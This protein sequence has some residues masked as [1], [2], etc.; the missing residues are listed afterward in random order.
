[1]RSERALLFGGQGAYA[2]GALMKLEGAAAGEVR[3]VLR[4]V[5][6]VAGE[7][8]RAGVS[9]LLRSAGGPGAAELAERDPFAL[10]LAIF[11]IGVAGQR[12]ASSSGDA[13]FVGHSMG[14]IAALTAAGAFELADGARLV[15]HRAEALAAACRRRGGMLSVQLS[16]ARAA[17][18][19]ELVDDPEAAVAVRNAPGLT[20]LA[21]PE[22]ALA[23]FVRIADAMHVRSSRLPAPYAF[24]SPMMALAA[25]RFA[26]AIGPIRQRPLR[27]RVYSPVAQ[28]FVH[29]GMDLKLLLAGQLTAQVDFLGA[30]RALHEAGVHH[31][32]EAIPSG[33]SALVKRSV[34]GAGPAVEVG[35]EELARGTMELPVVAMP[36][37]RAA[38]P[39]M[40]EAAA[41]APHAPHAPTLSEVLEQLRGLYADT[42]GYP[43]E[44]ITPDADLEADLGIDSLKRAE[45]LAKVTVHFRLR[46][47][48]DGRYASHQTLAEL[49]GLVVASSEA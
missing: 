40:P 30:L 23:S 34:P 11:A 46:D 45:M 12:L 15:C 37:E 39:G 2:P 38:A 29:D 41:S 14:E 28:R 13:V 42:L 32:F 24:H 9:E 8:G 43:P 5:D 4:V 27:A 19:V 31:F 33:L 21:G 36:E 48:D 35:G 26:A 20:V 49:A 18:L 1:M 6:G 7:F 44:A 10:Q 25:E 47:A 22:E 3:E 17:H 16:A